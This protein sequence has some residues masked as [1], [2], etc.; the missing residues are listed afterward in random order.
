VKMTMSNESP[1]G[2]TP[3]NARAHTGS[4]ERLRKAVRGTV[5]ER[6]STD[7][8]DARRIFNGMIDRRPLAI[9]QPADLGDMKE[10]LLIAQDEGLDLA[11]RGGGHNV[12]GLALVDD[13]VVIDCSGLRSVAVDEGNRL[14]TCQP[15][16]LW[17]E[18][19]AATHA[20]GLATTGG[21]ISD[22]GVAGLT[23]GGGLGWLMGLH[24]LS[25]DN[26]VEADVLLADGELVLASA[27]D[28]NDLLWALRGGG[29]N[30]GVV[31]R[32]RF[33][34][35]PVSQVFAGS[36]VYPI[37]RCREAMARF[38]DLGDSSPDA[39]TMSFVAATEP[40]GVKV[41]SLDACYCGTQTG[42]SQTTAPLLAKRGVLRDTRCKLPYVQWQRAFNDPFRRGRRSYWKAQ[43]VVDLSDTFADY[44]QD[45][46]KTAPSPHTML[47]IDHV[48]GA[49]ARVPEGATAFAHRSLRYLFLL[50]TNWDDPADDLINIEWTRRLFEGLRAFGPPSTYV[51]YLSLE[52]EARTRE[53]YSP[54]V[55][56]RLT[57]VKAKY[58]PGNVFHVNQNIRPR[59]IDA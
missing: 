53:A 42:G 32:L 33:R 24:G 59:G 14:A 40:S 51:N 57:A 3:S 6:T 2:G 34:L 48:H 44:V 31:T 21:I 27:T 49:A 23:L 28:H 55:T 45:A 30:F 56:A 7:Y 54:E 52:G 29:G 15:G 47:T 39:L 12:A 13:G 46:L 16:V 25:C 1:K 36:V 19:D 35:H 26:L 18:L 4:V 41:A 5:L 37:E 43:Y 10:A 38:V 17:G 20:R 22:T 9:V 11:I 58:D 8:D 50:N